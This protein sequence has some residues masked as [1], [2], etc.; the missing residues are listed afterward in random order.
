MINIQQLWQELTP[1]YNSGEAK[2]I[3][4]TV[5][6]VRFGLTLVD[7]LC[8]KVNEFSAEER[9][10]L[11]E[12][13]QRL[14]KGEP[15]QYILGR[16]D[17]CGH[18]FKV[19]PGVLIPRPETAELCEL[20]IQQKPQGDILDIGTGSGCIAITLALALKENAQ[21]TAWDL[22]ENALHIAE[23]NARELRA[24]VNFICQDALQTPP[25]HNLWNC[26]VSNPPYIIEKERTDMEKNVLDYEPDMALFVPNDDPLRFYRSITRYAKNALRPEGALYFEINPLYVDTMK[27]LI[28][29]EGFRYP[30]IHEDLFGKP[31]I[32][33]AHL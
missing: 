23:D 17:F 33:E 5:L 22:S 26:I 28:Y 7:I 30:V 8:D 4:R 3:I 11:E 32:L 19:A 13:I 15:I 14:K 31:R 12:I 21:I 25:D 20:I 2:A 24:N 6:E 9:Q 29:K 27:S 18:T 1:L 10:T 16:T